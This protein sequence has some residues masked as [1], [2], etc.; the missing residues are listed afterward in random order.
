MGHSAH[1]MGMRPEHTLHECE[2]AHLREV[3]FL[4]WKESYSFHSLKHAYAENQCQNYGELSVID[5]C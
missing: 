4:Q 3:Y 5:L 2:G 1:A